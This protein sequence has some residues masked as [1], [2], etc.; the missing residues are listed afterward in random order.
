ME[1]VGRIGKLT[2]EVLEFWPWGRTFLIQ[3]AQEQ[4]LPWPASTS[5]QKTNSHDEIRH[6][7]CCLTLRLQLSME[8]I[9]IYTTDRGNL[10][11]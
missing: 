2:T 9:L 3:A 10:D 8:S 11:K 7:A 5:W 6:K 4:S 1:G